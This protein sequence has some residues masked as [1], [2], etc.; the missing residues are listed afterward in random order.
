MRV[1][2]GRVALLRRL[3]CSDVV[4][5]GEPAGTIFIGANHGTITRTEGL[6]AG[7]DQST[8]YDEQSDQANPQDAE[9]EDDDDG[10]QNIIKRRIKEAFRQARDDVKRTF[11]KVRRSFIDFFRDK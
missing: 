10:D 5:G 3:E 2:M 11:Y 7:S 9:E 8:I 6:F 1:A 4:R